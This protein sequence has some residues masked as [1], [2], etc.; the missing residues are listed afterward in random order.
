TPCCFYAM[1][2]SSTA[3]RHPPQL[4]LQSTERRW[5]RDMFRI[6]LSTFRERWQLFV[7]SILMA[8]FGVALVQSSLLILV[9]AATFDA[10]AGL[11]TIERAHVLDSFVLAIPVIGITLALSIFLTVFIIS[12]TFAFTVAQRKRDLALMRLTGGSRQQLR[13]LLLGEAT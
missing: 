12:S 3:L 4:T 7:G 6:S 10:P 11:S 9:S 1:A 2:G 13:R 8:G 5:S